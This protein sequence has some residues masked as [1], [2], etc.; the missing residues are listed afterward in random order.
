MKEK[1]TQIGARITPMYYTILE[2]ISKVNKESLTETIQTVLEQ[3]FTPE[4]L[5]SKVKALN[6]KKKEI[7]TAIKTTASDQM[8]NELQ[9]QLNQFSDIVARFEIYIKDIE[10]PKK[11]TKI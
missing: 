3:Y 1:K 8:K 4:I 2:D 5:K 6:T 7:E 10:K 9:I 11:Q